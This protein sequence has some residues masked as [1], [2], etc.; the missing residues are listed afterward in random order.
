[1]QINETAARTRLQLSVELKVVS[2]LL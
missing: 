2:D 1:V